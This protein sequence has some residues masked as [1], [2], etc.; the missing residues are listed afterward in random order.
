[1]GALLLA[2]IHL[3]GLVLQEKEEK[4]TAMEKVISNPLA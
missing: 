2:I 4:Q 3:G 1:M